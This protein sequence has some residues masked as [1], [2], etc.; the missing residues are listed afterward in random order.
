M[1]V[2]R[3]YF[4]FPTCKITV[5]PTGNDFD[6]SLSFSP[7]IRTP[8]PSINRNASDVLEAKPVIFMIWETGPAAIWNS[9]ISEGICLC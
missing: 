5:A 6:R 7:S 3:A 2:T 8:P 1:R 9:S 4:R